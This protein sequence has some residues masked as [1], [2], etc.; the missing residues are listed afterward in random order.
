MRILTL[1]LAVGKIIWYYRVKDLEKEVLLRN[2]AYVLA[3][4][5][6]GLDAM[7]RNKMRENAYRARCVNVDF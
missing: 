2:R 6:E 5:W 1:R 3:F 7:G 4:V